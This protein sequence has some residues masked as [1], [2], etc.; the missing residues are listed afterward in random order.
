M[1]Y[2]LVRIDDRVIHGQVAMRW[3]KLYPC[4]AI[5]VVDDEIADNSVLAKVYKAA[6]FGTKVYIFNKASAFI[7]LPEAYNSEKK[8]FVIVKS[9]NTLLDL[10]NHDVPLGNK[11]IYGPSSK[12]EGTINL[13]Q[14][15][16]LHPSEIESCDKLSANGISIVFQFLPETK[17]TKWEEI[18]NKK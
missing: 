17:A 14:K 10:M 6:A 15:F 3:S 16:N 11:I 4:D 5:I 2:S 9:P 7:K 12:E 13:D 18:R 8:Y 1:A